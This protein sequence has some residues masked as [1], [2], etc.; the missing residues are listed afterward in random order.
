[1]C[2]FLYWLLQFPILLLSPQRVRHF[3]TAKSIIVPTAWL[4]ILIWAVV[5][6]PAK[7]SLSQTR[8]S[9]SGSQL[10]W[11]WLSA[12]NSSLGIYATLAI[13]IPD[14]TVSATP[15]VEDVLLN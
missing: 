9:L 7:V 5:K 10:G 4:A 6:V 13:N 11:A 2:Y 12:L 3:F 15:R 14:F 1:M 8:G